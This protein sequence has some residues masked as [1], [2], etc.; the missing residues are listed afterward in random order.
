MGNVAKFLDS[1]NFTLSRKK[2]LKKKKKKNLRALAR[3]KE[4]IN[5]KLLCESAFSINIP[6]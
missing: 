6:P 2:W 5:A 1:Y 3:K 4:S